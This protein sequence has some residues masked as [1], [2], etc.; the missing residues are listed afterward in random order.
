VWRSTDGGRTWSQPQVVNDRPTSAREGLHAMAADSEGHVAMAWLDDRTP[1]NGKKLYAA[2][3]NDAGA[4]WSKN[5]ALYLSPSGSI[6]ECCHPSLVSLGHG[7]FA[8]M[9]RNS[10]DGSRDF[11]AL[12][13]RDGK[14]VSAPEKQGQG[15]WK[16]NA[17]PMDGGGIGIR[18]GQLISA[19]RREHDIYLAETG[20]PEVKLGP[21]QDVAL[22]VSAKGPFA[23]WT[24]EKGL[25]LY[26]PGA[27]APTHLSDTGAFPS[28]VAL[29]DGS[30]LTAWEENGS[31]ALRRVE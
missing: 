6:C 23:V 1:P 4:T 26:T 27:S 28:A 15:T 7:E 9:W 2:F 3:S 19:W 24:G 13:I 22:A 30:V 8:V 25:E 16:L 10:L 17:C 11:Y 20:K 14:A 5:A 12:R 29:A 18:N 21:G 31:I